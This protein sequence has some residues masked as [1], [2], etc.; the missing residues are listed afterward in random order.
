MD[1]TMNWMRAISVSAAAYRASEK[2]NRAISTDMVRHWLRSGRVEGRKFG[3]EWL[4]TAQGVEQI[5][6]IYRVAEG[7]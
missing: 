6:S 1:K 3:R 7:E 4:V 5:A 2:S